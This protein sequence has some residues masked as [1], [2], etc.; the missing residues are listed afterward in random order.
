VPGD[1]VREGDDACEERT[2]LAGA[3]HDSPADRLAWEALVDVDA[4]L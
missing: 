3:A 2:R 4:F 1:L